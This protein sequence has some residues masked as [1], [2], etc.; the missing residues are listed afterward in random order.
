MKK[1]RQLVLQDNFL[2]ERG[3]MAILSTMRGS[4]V[5]AVNFRNNLL[6]KESM[7]DI[8]KNMLRREN[9]VITVKSSQQTAIDTSGVKLVKRQTSCAMTT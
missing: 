2:G 9:P 8:V 1:L 5:R 3:V 6:S 7:H 4:K